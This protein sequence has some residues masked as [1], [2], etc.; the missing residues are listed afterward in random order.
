[1]VER[2]GG[3][4][5]DIQAGVFVHVDGGGIA[6]LGLDLPFVAELLEPLG[7]DV[8]NG[9]EFGVIAA[10]VAGCVGE[11]PASQTAYWSGADNTD[12]DFGL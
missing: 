12:S 5:Y 6:V 10:P 9:D 3:D 4:V 8:G 11:G 1:M 7:V 2:V